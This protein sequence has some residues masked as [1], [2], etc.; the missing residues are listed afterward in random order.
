LDGQALDDCYDAPVGLCIGAPPSTSVMMG[1]GEHR[2]RLLMIAANSSW[3]PDVMMERAAKICTAFVAPS[4]WA[5][6]VVE[7]YAY[8]LPVHVFPHG[9]DPAFKP[10]EKCPGYFR[11]LHLASTHMERKGTKSLIEAWATARSSGQLPQEATLR[12]IVDGPRGHFVDAIVKHTGSQL[13]YGETGA[14]VEADGFEVLPR[15]DLKL[16]D[17]AALYRDHHL[18][19]QPSRAEGFGMVPLEARACGVPV[20][21]TICTGHSTHMSLKTAGVVVVAH[22][23]QAPI[24]DGPGALAP[25]VSARDIQAA[26]ATA[27]ERYDELSAAAREVAPTIRD[28]WS[29][30]SVAADFLTKIQPILG[31]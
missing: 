10:G 28:V 27:Y 24:D 15:Q 5:A 14:T 20:V 22:G 4:S 19:V 12:L 11:A 29:W 26:L 2:H 8:G 3:L 6:G 30:E 23:L 21:A 31:A 7:R 13:R 1:R 17:M 25:L 16:Q 9:V 18:V